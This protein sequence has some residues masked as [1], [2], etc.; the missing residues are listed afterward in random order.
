MGFSEFDDAYED[1]TTPG[2]R[3]E[4][5]LGAAILNSTVRSLEP[6][7]AVSV[8]D[9]VSIRQAIRVMVERNIGAVLVERDGRPV[10]IFTER[11]VL[12]RV[13][14]TGIDIG[15]PVA[16]VM[17]PDPQTLGPHDAI[18]FALNFMIVQGFRHIPI[19]DSDDK[20]Q[21][22]LSL[23]EVVAF[24]VSLL[25]ARVLNLPPKPHLEARSHHGG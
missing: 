9:D 10:G 4:Q 1:D 25:P 6:H 19:V 22:V 18:T 15:R 2:E 13:A 23:R 5:R 16:D 7:P 3:E 8:A 11:D 21:T 20:V 14:A 24:V 12:R 17:T